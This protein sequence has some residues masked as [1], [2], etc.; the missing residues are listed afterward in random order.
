MSRPD[1]I[2]VGTPVVAS[3]ELRVLGSSKTVAAG[4]EGVVVSIGADDYTDATVLTV[5]WRGIRK[6]IPYKGAGITLL[7]SAPA[8]EP[9]THQ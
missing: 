4:T 1:L 8:S 2:E 9:E 3:R 5:K 7:A 6:P